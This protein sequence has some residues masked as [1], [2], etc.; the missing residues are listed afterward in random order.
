[1]PRYVWLVESKR[2]DG[3]PWKPVMDRCPC[4]TKALAEVEARY[5][6]SGAMKGIGRYRV[7]KYVRVP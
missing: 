7:A 1:M 5:Q 2:I 6:N 3:G 4:R